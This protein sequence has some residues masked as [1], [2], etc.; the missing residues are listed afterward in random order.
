[1]DNAYEK[2]ASEATDRMQDL[3]LQVGIDLTRAEQVRIYEFFHKWINKPLPTAQFQ[4]LQ[5]RYEKEQA[6]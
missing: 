3:F 6:K 2:F 5:A 4:A 1:M